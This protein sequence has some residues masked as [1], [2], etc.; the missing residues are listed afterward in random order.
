MA[1]ADIQP[2]DM[3]SLNAARE[4]RLKEVAM[5]AIL[6]EVMIYFVFVMVTFF[7]SYQARDSNSFIFAQNI[8]NTFF[9]NGAP[10]FDSVR[11]QLIFT[12]PENG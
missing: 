10:Y 12:I 1:A 9:W 3:E 4:L 11:L 8:K 6:K 5:E 7:L 2:P